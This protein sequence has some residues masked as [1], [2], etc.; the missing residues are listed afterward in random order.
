MIVLES[1]DVKTNMSRLYTA[2]YNRVRKYLTQNDCNFAFPRTRIFSLLPSYFDKY[3]DGYATL[4][5]DLSAFIHDFESSKTYYH[6]EI[7][8]LDLS[9]ISFLAQF[10]I[11]EDQEQLAATVS[12]V[13]L[14]SKLILDTLT[15]EQKV[16]MSLTNGILNRFISMDNDLDLFLEFYQDL[17]K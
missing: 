13:F 4:V 3:M 16:F 10:G 2:D 9:A 5:R 11:F 8:N 17:R 1:V 6:K 15:E 7:F 14:I 12:D